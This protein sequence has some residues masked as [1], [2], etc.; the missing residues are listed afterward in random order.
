VATR[1]LSKFIA[2]VGHRDAP[3]VL[4]LGPVVGSNVS[5][6]G[7]RLGCRL[8]V[9]DLYSDLDRLTK[10]GQFETL[11]EV[12]SARLT[13]APESLDAILCWDVFDYLDKPAAKALGE[14]VGQ[15]IKPGGVVLCFFSTVANP[16]ATYTRYVITDAQH[17]QHRT[18]TASHARRTV[19]QNRDIDRLFP[20]LTV[21]ESVLLLNK[22]REV[23]LRKRVPK[24]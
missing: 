6:L 18:S 9:E 11:T 14:R 1:V 24:A 20:G 4:D 23:L 22:T 2:A 8:L 3:V 16:A 19:Y 13:H 15:W 10:A 12:L 21:T 17:L 5:F 7:E